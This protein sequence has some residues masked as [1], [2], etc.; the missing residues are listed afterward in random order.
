MRKSA[1]SPGANLDPAEDF[2]KMRRR[3]IIAEDPDWS[4]NIVPCLSKLCLQSIGRNF[5]EKPIFEEL[6]PIQKDF[7]QE[8]VSTSLPLHVTANLISD[9]VYWKRCCEQR[10]DLCDVSHYGY[11]WKRMF[12]ERHMET[13]IELFIP[14]VTEPKTVLEMVPLCKNYIKRLDISQLL[15]PIK[16]PQNEEEEELGLELASDNE[17]DRPSLDH[18]DFNILLDKLTKLEELHLVYRVKQCGMNFEWKMFEMTTRDCESLAKALKSCMTLKLLKLHQ[19]HIEDVK[20][21]LLV[22]YLLDH[23][24]LR[25]LDFSHNLIG[26]KGARAL[27]KLLNRSKLTTLNMCDNEIRGPG[28]KAI[29]YALSKNSTLKSLNLRLNRL[30]DDGGQ[31]IGKALL[32]NNT[33]LHLHLGGNEVTGPTANALSKVLIQ[34]NTLKSINLSCNNLGVDGGKA[35]EEAMSHNTSVTEFDIGLTGVDN[36]SVSF[37]NQVVWTN[38]SLEKERHAQE[39]KHQ[40]LPF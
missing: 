22:K 40:Q 34:S 28:A 9:G 23:P 24:S 5:E 35:L 29:A 27:G 33:L 39:S 4:L 30:R 7:V 21:R 15:P 1:Y 17:Y 18:F 10:W 36:Q 32:N 2:G 6:T 25:E 8:N 16:E 26:D 14:E 12:F 19:S 13:I 20:C 37:I 38:Q 11:S 31:A 3:R